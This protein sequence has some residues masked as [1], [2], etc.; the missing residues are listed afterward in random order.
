MRHHP[1][2]LTL[3][4]RWVQTGEVPFRIYGSRP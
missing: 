1:A 3:G 2:N 4:V